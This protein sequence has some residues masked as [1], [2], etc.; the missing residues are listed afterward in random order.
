[1][2]V[3]E[4]ARYRLGVNAGVAGDLTGYGPATNAGAPTSG[5]TFAGTLEKGALVIDITNAK[6]YINTGTKA[7]PTWTVVG[8][9][10]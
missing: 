10:S 8:S 1:M 5:T 2:P 3:I 7:N 4:G 6:L 9:Q